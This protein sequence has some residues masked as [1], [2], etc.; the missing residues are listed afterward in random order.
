MTVSSLQSGYVFG[1]FLS[2]LLQC[3][4]RNRD[5][6][7]CS[8]SPY[9]RVTSPSPVSAFTPCTLACSCVCWF[10]FLCWASYLCLFPSQRSF[11]F[12]RAISFFLDNFCI[13][14][15]RLADI[16][17]YI[18]TYVSSPSLSLSP[19]LFFPCIYMCLTPLLISRSV[20]WTPQMLE[21]DAHPRLGSR[22]A[23]M[24]LEGQ[25]PLDE[26]VV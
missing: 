24:E 1:S 10:P 4:E 22:T 9:H 25:D 23:I 7:T 13:P 17:V 20:S 8:A 2:F 11:P 19:S 21:S 18:Y 3:C 16:C 26:V 5:P 14:S 12:L 15:L 6:C